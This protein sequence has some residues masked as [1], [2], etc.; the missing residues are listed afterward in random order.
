M[1]IIEG[2]I[3]SNLGNPDKNVS[4]RSIRER[5]AY[6]INPR[7]WELKGVR[8]E[9]LPQDL[10]EATALPARDPDED[11]LQEPSKLIEGVGAIIAPFITEAHT[12]HIPRPEDSHLHE[13][14]QSPEQFT[15]TK[16][17]RLQQSDISHILR[18]AADK[19]TRGHLDPPPTI[20]FSWELNK[21]ETWIEKGEEYQEA[22]KELSLYYRNLTKDPRQMTDYERDRINV[23]RESAKI[24]P[25]VAVNDNDEPLGAL[26]LRWRGDP[27]VPEHKR[28]ASFERVIVNP[29]EH[30][31]RKG[32]GTLLYTKALDYA[33][34]HGYERKGANEVRAWVLVDDEAGFFHKNITMLENIG[35]SIIPDRRNKD[36]RSYKKARNMDTVDNRQ[37]YW[38]QIH[39]ETWR[40][41]KE[42]S[43][44][45]QE[46]AKI[47]LE[48]QQ[49]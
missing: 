10:L 37:A 46:C 15:A 43:L 49:A 8:K 9:A 22:V 31:R 1:G 23:S 48:L 12:I 6:H 38:Y 21:P 4:G 5:L 44:K 11:E 45:L 13:N 35:F 40:E 32:T 27:Y 24:T 16:V 33:F 20:P 29:D 30:Y 3:R 26:T 17:R 28:I 14:L 42:K 2:E 41:V 47:P 39:K 25:L 7:N 34:E 19:E 18:W 36:W